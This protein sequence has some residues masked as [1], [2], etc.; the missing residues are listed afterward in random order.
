MTCTV[1]SCKNIRRFKPEGVTFHRLPRDSG[2]LEQW[3]HILGKDNLLDLESTKYKLIC[4]KHFER[5]CFIIKNGKKYLVPSAVPSLRL[6]STPSRREKE[7]LSS[8]NTLQSSIDSSRASTSGVGQIS[9]IN[10]FS[11][12]TGSSS[13][14]SRKRRRKILIVQRDHSYK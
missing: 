2:K 4:S 1:E 5:N 12:S 3:L 9:E 10:R 7:G 6:S 8:S 14:A 11:S 13:N